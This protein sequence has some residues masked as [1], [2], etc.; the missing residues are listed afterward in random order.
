MRHLMLNSRDVK[1]SALGSV[2]WLALAACGPA[3]APP[4]QAPS[5]PP[6]A[7]SSSA[8]AAA[9]APA[10][11]AA[12]APVAVPVTPAIAAAFAASDRSSDDRALDAGRK[13]D[14]M[15][16]FFGLAPGMHVAE[17]GAGTGY[18]TE[19]M[20]RVV[21]PTGVVYGQNGQFF[22]QKFAEG[23]WS[24]RLATPPMKRVVRV[25]REFDDP[26]PPEAKNLDAVLFIL[27]YHDTVW[28]EADRERMN[29]S[30]F[31][32]LRPGGVYGIV[33]HSGRDGT[34]TTETK[35]LHR[36]EE[37]VVLDEV[38]HAGFVLD[39]EGTFLKN[40]AD[41]RDWNASP[42]A[43]AERRGTTDRFALRFKK[44]G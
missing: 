31:A 2:A 39:A 11:A 32:A 38:K 34:G 42:K 24:A 40:P 33:D 21:G 19:L 25:D 12:S 18:T 6:P 10:P 43:A 28:L 13:A 7:A 41:T 26:L 3:Q 37:K 44:P 23:P 36:I 14:Q 27:V 16:S 22:L 9:S 29:R 17:L 5:A 20:A 8:S 30:V 1:F 4:A 35:T 15:L